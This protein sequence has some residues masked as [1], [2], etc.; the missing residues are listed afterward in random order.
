[1]Y[2]HIDMVT[3][4]TTFDKPVSSTGLNKALHGSLSNQAYQRQRIHASIVLRPYSS[5]F[6]ESRKG[7]IGE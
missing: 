6:C 4:G 2:Y 3:Y 5:L 1:M 7:N